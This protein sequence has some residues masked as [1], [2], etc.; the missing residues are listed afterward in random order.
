MVLINESYSINSKYIMK[1]NEIIVFHSFIKTF[2][3]CN[4]ELIVIAKYCVCRAVIFIR[5]LHYYIQ[6]R[7]KCPL[8]YK[9]IKN[10]CT[11]VLTRNLK[12]FFPAYL[13]DYICSTMFLFYFAVMIWKTAVKPDPILDWKNRMPWKYIWHLL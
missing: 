11:K 8:S 9:N 10:K 1:K 12:L 3:G 7:T 13:K 6:I 5:S 2:Q 4:N